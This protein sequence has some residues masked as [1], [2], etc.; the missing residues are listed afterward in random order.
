MRQKE[1]KKPCGQKKTS[2]R[3]KDK[4]KDRVVSW[5]QSEKRA[6]IGGCP[7]GDLVNRARQ[8]TW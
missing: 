8:H 1:K 2:K 3:Y 4:V 7:Y 5:N 6:T